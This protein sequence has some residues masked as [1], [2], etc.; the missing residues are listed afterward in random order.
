MRPPGIEIHA[1]FLIHQGL[2]QPHFCVTELDG[3]SW[4]THELPF[5]AY[6]AAAARVVVAAD[7]VPSPDAAGFFCAAPRSSTCV[8]SSRTIRRPLY[9]P[10]PATHF[11][12]PS[13]PVFADASTSHT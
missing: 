6:F 7:S 4:R 8:L 13:R 3:Q 9:F 10:S 1:A 2:Q 5:F 11:C 12:R